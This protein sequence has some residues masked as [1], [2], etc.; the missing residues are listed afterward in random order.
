MLEGLSAATPLAR[1]TTSKLTF[2]TAFDTMTYDFECTNANEVCLTWEFQLNAR[3]TENDDSM[4]ISPEDPRGV[5]KRMMNKINVFNF[6]HYIQIK[7]N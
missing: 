6:L 5:I 3:H 1:Y 2:W 4:Y 7:L